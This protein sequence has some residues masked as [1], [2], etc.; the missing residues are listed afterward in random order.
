MEFE[1]ELGW[2]GRG[3]LDVSVGVGEGGVVG[4][5]EGGRGGVPVGEEGIDDLEEVG[6]RGGGG[7]DEGDVVDSD[8]GLG[9]VW[10]NVGGVPDVLESKAE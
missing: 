4:D 2:G 1:E 6:R 7:Y 3:S 10:H 9:L 5:E 8:G